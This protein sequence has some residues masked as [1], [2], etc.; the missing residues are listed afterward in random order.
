MTFQEKGNLLSGCSLQIVWTAVQVVPPLTEIFLLSVNS[1]FISFWVSKFLSSTHGTVPS[2][3]P[4]S[5]VSTVWCLSV[6]F[7]HTENVGSIP[8][9]TNESVCK[10]NYGCR[11]LPQYLCLAFLS[12]K[13]PQNYSA[14]SLSVMCFSCFLF[15]PFKRFGILSS[16]S[17]PFA[18]W[19]RFP[20]CLN[21]M[22]SHHFSK[23]YLGEIYC[24]ITIS[25]VVFLVAV[26]FSL[27]WVRVNGCI[28]S[29]HTCACV[30][31]RFQYSTKH[32][33]MDITHLVT[34][35]TRNLCPQPLGRISQTEW[36]IL[37]SQAAHWTRAFEPQLSGRWQNTPTVQ[38]VVCWQIR[39]S[40]STR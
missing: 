8:S 17:H 3:L 27:C 36:M 23:P 25:S 18:L 29:S 13:L 21:E 5:P 33:M 10:T 2:F 28:T 30:V 31:H 20:F 9:S 40:D 26:V 7:I 19:G 4:W 32:S 39:C 15:S 12:V 37:L 1:S 11:P 6:I 34:V 24:H 22:P 16:P 14:P 38:Q 35:E